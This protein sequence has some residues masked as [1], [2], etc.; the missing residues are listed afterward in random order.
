MQI[1]QDYPSCEV[2]DLAIYEFKLE[3]A[4]VAITILEDTP[5]NRKQQSRVERLFKL[6]G[7]D[8]PVI[9]VFHDTDGRVSE[10]AEWSVDKTRDLKILL[11]K[12]LQK[13]PA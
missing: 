4:G 13:T 2:L 5:V 11:G 3:R 1:I 10:L 12:E 8:P 6:L 7:K 9:V